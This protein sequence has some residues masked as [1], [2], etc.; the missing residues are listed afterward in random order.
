MFEPRTIL[1]LTFSIAS[2]LIYRQYRN[3]EET[4]DEREQY[5]FAKEYF[6]G[7]NTIH[8]RKPYL[9]IHAQGELNARNWESFGSRGS[10]DLNQPY[11]VMTIKSILSKCKDSFNI[12]L[13]DDD[14]FRKLVPG[15]KIDMDLLPSPVKEHYRQ[16]G[17]TSLLCEYGGMTVPASTLCLEDLQSLYK[18]FV[19]KSNSSDAFTVQTG[20]DFP[21]PKFM[22]S[23]KKG[24]TIQAFQQYQGAMLKR[25]TSAESDFNEMLSQWCKAKTE[26]VCGRLVGIKK[27]CGNPVDLSELLGGNPVEF[28]DDL[29][30]IY[31]PSETILKRPKYAWF[32]RMSP[33]QLLSSDLVLAHY[34]RL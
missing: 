2:W 19:A 22:G 4:Y 16:F 10:K 8:A 11:L 33:T 23:V 1:V 6:I 28:H 31:I 7:D 34:F 17:L 27:K 20:V 14:S 12:F 21:D 24:D 32:A 30:A 9:W 13:I 15:W 29:R 18:T 3:M 26:V 5:R 25:D